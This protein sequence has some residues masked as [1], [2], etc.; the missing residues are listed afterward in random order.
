MLPPYTHVPGRTPHPINDPAGH[1]YGKPPDDSPPPTLTDWRQ[2]ASL[3]HGAELFE[4]G[5]YWE[6]HETWEQAWVAAGR[7][8][9][10]A[11]F[12]KGLIKL[13]AAGVKIYEGQPTGVQRHAT[14]AAE[15]FTAVRQEL[16]DTVLGYSLPKLIAL[17]RTL[18]AAPPSSHSADTPGQPRP[19]LSLA[20]ARIEP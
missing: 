12:L 4:A 16:G 7:R 11:D 13:A 9:T 20:T 1:S 5:Y 8:G 14:R 3:R 6:A 15:L 18:A 17:A 19:L 10:I 2:S